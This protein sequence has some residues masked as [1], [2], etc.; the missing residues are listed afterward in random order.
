M[1]T[2]YT[3]SATPSNK[4]W[5]R[6]RIGDT[7]R[8][9]VG[10]LLEDEDINAILGVQ[11]DLLLAAAQCCELIAADFSRKADFSNLSISVSASQRAKAYLQMAS[12]LRAQRS[13]DALQTAT[14]EFNGQTIAE[15]DRY[16][17]DTALLQPRFR[18]GGDDHPGTNIV[19]NLR[20]T[21][22]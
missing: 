14:F 1:T 21:S 20:S 15:R 7:N 4:D 16:R 18:R 19:D 3:A 5:V 22:S 8:A 13:A 11:T 2:T 12:D 17:A 10:W 9:S 6:L